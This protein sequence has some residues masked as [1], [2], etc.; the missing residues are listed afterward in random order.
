M[1][2]CA[3]I[4]D[5]PL[6]IQLLSSYV[7]QSKDLDLVGTYTNPIEALHAL[8]QTDVELVF[9]D[10]QMA[11][12][13]GLQFMKIAKNKYQFVLTTAYESYALESYDFNVIDYLLKPISLERFLS[14]VEKAKTRLQPKGTTG[15]LIVE[16]EKDFIFIKTGYKIQKIDLGAIRY[17]EGLGDYVA[18]HLTD[19]SKVLTLEKMKGFAQSLPESNFIRIHKSYL[20]AIDKIEFIEKN[21]VVINNQYLPVG[22]TYADGFWAKVKG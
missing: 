8:E 3:I 18:V 13:T 11:E 7:E 19:G 15:S 16:K 2:K 17:F 4:D 5:E 21:R 10:I 12:L 9:L 14:S 6:A 1:I 22:N 20:I